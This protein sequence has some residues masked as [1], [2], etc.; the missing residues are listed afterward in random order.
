MR[1]LA[2]RVGH[3]AAARLASAADDDASAAADPDTTIDADESAATHADAALD[4]DAAA[5][6]G[7][8]TR[9]LAATCTGT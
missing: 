8:A 4:A 3:R 6:G 5:H 9:S 7:R 1:R 2:R